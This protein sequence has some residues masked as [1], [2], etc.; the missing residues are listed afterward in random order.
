MRKE[1]FATWFDTPYYHILY[2]NRNDDE[3]K[4]FIENLVHYLDLP[5]SANVLDL[6][7]GKGRHSLTLK[8]AGYN[9][10][11]VDLSKNS[12]NDARIHQKEG[13]SF[14]V[15]DMREVIIG[16][17]FSAVFNLFTSFGYFEDKKDNLKVL[18]S[19]RKMLSDNGLLIIDFMNAQ[20]VIDGLVETELK[21][22][23]GVEFD[24]QRNYDGTH[25]YKEIR[26]TGEDTPYHYTE[27]VQALK[28]EDFESLLK[29]SDF[30]ILCTFGDFALKPFD[31]ST[32]DRLI[33]IAK[34]K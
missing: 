1:W 2:K 7:C 6:A 16:R 12:I 28:L 13:L 24:I 32:S 34:K 9:V 25:I 31:V 10:L 5:T 29:A 33:I 4:A 27:R 14:D 21:I 26:F 15:H 8:E 3:A 22:V 20:K 19:V 18:E 11:G 30:E 17:T 23:D